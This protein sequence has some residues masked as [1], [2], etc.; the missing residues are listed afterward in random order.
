MSDITERVR[1]EQER[2]QAQEVLRES[3]AR[4]RELAEENVRKPRINCIETSY[5][6][7]RD[8][9]ALMR[10]STTLCLTLSNGYCLFADPDALPTL[11]H[12]HNWY[13]F[14]DMKL[15][16]ATGAAVKRADGSISR[17]F[18]LGTAVYNPVG[19]RT[20]AVAFPEARTSAA[21]GRTA[22]EHT[23]NGGDGD[24]F[25]K[26]APQPAAGAKRSP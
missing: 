24:L 7:S 11:D 22:K 12:L 25:L 16:K 3:E 21:T 5:R 20:T 6:K 4:Y 23:V 9:L 17:E 13:P 18:D 10:A 2:Q 19:S 14:W 26:A 1:S 15:G 8:D